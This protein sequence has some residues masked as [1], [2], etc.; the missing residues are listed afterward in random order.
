MTKRVDLPEGLPADLAATHHELDLD[1]I[2]ARTYFKIGRHWFMA[3]SVNLR[4]STYGIPSRRDED[5]VRDFDEVEMR[6]VHAHWRG[7][8]D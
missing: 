1:E 4:T 2:A 3:Q 5:P 7:C 6:L 8:D